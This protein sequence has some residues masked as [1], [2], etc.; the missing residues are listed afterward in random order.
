MVAEQVLLCFLHAG[1]VG[2]LHRDFRSRSGLCN[3]HVFPEED[4]LNLRL[5]ACSIPCIILT[6]AALI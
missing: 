1:F 2:L 3:R 6:D 5:V 4:V